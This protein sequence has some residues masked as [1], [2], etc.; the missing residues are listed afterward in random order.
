MLKNVRSSLSEAKTPK[1]DGVVT[2]I[3]NLINP[4]AIKQGGNSHWR[5]NK[6][7]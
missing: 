5:G 1:Q 2:D 3:S 7:F 6:E 4:G